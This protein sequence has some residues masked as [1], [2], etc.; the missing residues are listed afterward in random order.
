MSGVPLA[1]FTGGDPRDEREQTFLDTGRDL[2]SSW[3]VP[4]VLPEHTSSGTF[5]RPLFLTVDV[6]GLPA[7]LANLQVGY[8]PP[9]A[10]PFGHALE[11]EWGDD[12]V[13][14]NHVYGREG[15]T[16][17]GLDA[18]PEEFG[19]WAVKWLQRQL[20]RPLERREWLDDS[21]HV[22]ATRYVFTDTDFVL[23]ESGFSVFRK[24]RRPPDRAEQVR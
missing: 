18:S 24:F 7:T 6:P 15:L 14:D 21:G 19:T 12:L 11:G 1:W 2:A 13:L 9:S 10:G 23:R 17:F 8:W 3:A 4:G 20:L 5:I 22:A 16:V